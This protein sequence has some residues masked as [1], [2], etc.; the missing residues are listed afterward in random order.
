MGRTPGERALPPADKCVAEQVQSRSMET[1]NVDIADGVI[2]NKPQ[3]V[4]KEAK[5]ALT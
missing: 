4:F 1:V 5:Q 3:E 2:R